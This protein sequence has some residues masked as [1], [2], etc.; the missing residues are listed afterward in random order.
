MSTRLTANWTFYKEPSDLWNNVLYDDTLLCARLV[1]CCSLNQTTSALQHEC[2]AQLIQ[3]RLW[4]KPKH[5]C[6]VWPL[7]YTTLLVFSK[8][9]ALW[10]QG[11]Y[12]KNGGFIKVWNHAVVL[13]ATVSGPQKHWRAA[14]RTHRGRSADRAHLFH[15]WWR[16]KWPTAAD[17][18]INRKPNW[19]CRTTSVN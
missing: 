18:L 10:I 4:T 5:F 19:I 17:C 2:R 1:C 11:S 6:C 14:G 13:K 9:E 7:A 16:T 8:T 15:L 3:R 12:S